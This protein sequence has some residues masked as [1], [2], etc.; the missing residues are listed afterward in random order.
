[1]NN[2]GSAERKQMNSVYYG[3][4]ENKHKIEMK[5]IKSTADIEG[6]TAAKASKDSSAVFIIIVIVIA[7]TLAE[8]LSAGLSPV[9]PTNE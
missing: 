5:G 6:A 2:V 3:S 7:S 8:G 4:K 9:R 1:M